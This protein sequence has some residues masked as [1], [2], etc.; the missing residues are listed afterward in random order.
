MAWIQI[1][2]Q[3]SQEGVVGRKE[4]LEI[5]EPHQSPNTLSSG[6]SASVSCSQ[7]KHT[8]RKQVPKQKQNRVP[9]AF[10]SEDTDNYT[11]CSPKGLLCQRSGDSSASW[12]LSNRV[13]ASIIQTIK[14]PHTGI[15]EP[16]C[17]ALSRHQVE[18]T[19]ASENLS[20]ESGEFQGSWAHVGAFNWPWNTDGSKRCFQ[21]Q[22]LLR[23]E[24]DYPC[25]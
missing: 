9:C 12:E 18:G 11:L 20:R 3:R 14:T 5:Q 23:N 19:G 21:P 1:S 8:V 24:S 6:E 4:G 15:R 13:V 10:I 7:W 22:G 2:C 16:T 17:L 25:S